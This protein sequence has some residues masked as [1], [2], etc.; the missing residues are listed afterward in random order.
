MVTKPQEELGLGK[1]FSKKMAEKFFPKFLEDK[2]LIRLHGLRQKDRGGRVVPEPW[3]AESKR[4]ILGG[5]NW[6]GNFWVFS[7]KIDFFENFQKFFFFCS[8]QN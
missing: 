2:L 5:E 1:K 8:F 3:G 4:S 7:R 6:V